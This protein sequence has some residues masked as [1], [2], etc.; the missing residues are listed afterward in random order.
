MTDHK[1]RYFVP[2]YPSPFCVLQL[3]CCDPFVTLFCDTC[4]YILCFSCTSAI[5]LCFP[6]LLSIKAVHRDCLL[7]LH[8][9]YSYLLNPKKIKSRKSSEYPVC[10]T[11]DS[12]Q[13]VVCILVSVLR[14]TIQF[15]CQIC[16]Y[17]FTGNRISCHKHSVF[18]KAV[19]NRGSLLFDKIR[20]I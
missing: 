9:G 18:S 8:L 4:T 13:Q 7:C 5:Y 16:L 11:V 3:L 14:C 6:P 1:L 10:V 19:L 2:D 17:A 15:L 12:R 20:I